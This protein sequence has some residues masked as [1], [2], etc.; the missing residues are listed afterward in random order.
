MSH[1]HGTTGRSGIRVSTSLAGFT[2]LC[3]ADWV[4][5]EDLGFLGGLRRG[6][7]GDVGCDRA[8][9]SGPGLISLPLSRTA[10]VRVHDQPNGPSSV[11]V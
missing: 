4:L 10:V 3:L 2:A 6:W 7:H 8:G 1:R 11:D 9:S 5:V